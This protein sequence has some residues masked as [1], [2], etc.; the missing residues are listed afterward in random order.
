MPS[1]TRIAT[2][3]PGLDDVLRGGL[4]RGSVYLIQGSPGAGKTI[5]ANQMCAAVAAGGGSALY[6]TLLSEGTSSIIEHMRSLSFV[7]EDA[8]GRSIRYVSALSAVEQ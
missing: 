1:P 7:D 5:L 4:L 2:G 3:V 6:V 8:L